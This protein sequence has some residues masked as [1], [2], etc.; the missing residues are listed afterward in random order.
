M[1]RGDRMPPDE[2]NDE[3][4]LEELEEDNQTPFSAPDPSR[5]DP[6]ISE[7]DSEDQFTAPKKN[8][9]RPLTDDLMDTT[10]YYNEGVSTDEPN[11]GNSVVDFKP[12]D[13]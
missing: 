3:E 10:E 11:Q 8:D 7:Q 6:A 4:K 13:E 1:N 2:P 9:D 12:K 5:E